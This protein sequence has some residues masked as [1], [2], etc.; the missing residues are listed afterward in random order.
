MDADGTNVRQLTD[1][2]ADDWGSGWVPA[3]EPIVFMSN[4]DGDTELF[5]MDADGTNV[6]QLTDNDADDWGS[7]WVPAGEPIVFTSNRDGDFELFVM[8][9][10]GTNVRQLTDNDADDR[11]FGWVPAGEPIVFMSNRDGDFELFVMDADGTNVRQLTD[12]DADDSGTRW[13]PDRTQVGFHSNRDGDFELFVMDA[14]GTNERQLTHND[15]LDWWLGWSPDGSRIAYSSSTDGDTLNS[16]IFVMDADGTNVHQLYGEPMNQ[17]SEAPPSESYRIAFVSNIGGHDAIYSVDL[18]SEEGI[19]KLGEWSAVTESDSREGSPS[20]SP[21]GSWIAFQRRTDEDS[22]W[23]I[24]ITN[25]ITGDE[26]QLLCGAENGWSPS[27]SSDGTRIAFA[28]GSGGEN[29]IVSIDIR[30]G[31]QSELKDKSGETDRLPRWSPDG[32]HVAFVRGTWPL[33]EIRILHVHSQAKN[34]DRV[35]WQDGDYTGPS[36]SPIGDQISY[37]LKGDGASYRHIYTADWLVIDAGSD[38]PELIIENAEQLTEDRFD[39]DEPSWSHDGSWIAFSREVGDNQG[40]FVVNSAGGEPFALLSH[41]AFSYSAPSWAPQTGPSVKPTY[42][43]RD[44]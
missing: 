43:C 23:Q 33:R 36:W 15:H 5:V 6:R 44:R 20:W 24:F 27:W 28:Q 42:D 30:T 34:V 19:L 14:D 13:S 39:D 41:G 25:V 29:D 11:E 3:G 17:V 31:E 12:N 7:G 40:I 9:A 18:E 37:A 32:R 1:N 21:D 35:L 8:D 22:H 2:D 10:D 4:R 26:R 16:P 38:D